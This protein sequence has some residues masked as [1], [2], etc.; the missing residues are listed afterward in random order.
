MVDQNIP[1]TIDDTLHGTFVTSIIVD[2]PNLN[3]DLDDGCG[4]F[5]VKHFGVAKAESFSSF[6]IMKNI[7]KI[8]SE[9]KDIKVWNLSLGSP[10]E[11]SKNSISPEASIL[12]RIQ[13]ENDVIFVISGTNKKKGVNKEMKIGSPADSINSIIVNSVDRNNKIASYS[14]FGEVLSFYRKPDICYYGGANGDFIA[15]HSGYEVCKVYG[16]SFAAPWI[17]RKVAYLIYILGFSK[18][19]AKA[20]IIDSSTG[21]EKFDNE[22]NKYGYGVVPVKITDIVSSKNDEIKFVISGISSKYE[23][24][25]Y[26]IPVPISN[27]KHPYVA[28]ATLVYFPSCSRNMGVDYTNSELDIYFGRVKKNSNGSVT[29]N[30]INE[31]HQSQEYDVGEKINDHS[32]ANVR[33]EFRK[34][35]NVKHIQE[36]L[37]TKNNRIKKPKTKLTSGMYGISIKKKNRNGDFDANIKY[38]L[39]ITLKDLEGKNRIDSFIQNCQLNG[40]LVNRIDIENKLEL[41]NLMDQEI[42]LK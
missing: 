5:K 13:K 6:S 17:T 2:G 7:E 27:D 20:L 19:V 14:R 41:Y 11:I 26:D 22:G 30:S 37:H 28:K 36:N 18:E 33:R 29:I 23:T 3:K 40:W 16:T 25:T 35:D 8:V 1:R 4:R 15:A 39:V 32:E 21:W 10:F 42:E 38:G 9:N 12:D 24:Y 34:W 31:N